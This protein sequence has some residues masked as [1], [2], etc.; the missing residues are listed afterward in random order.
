MGPDPGGPDPRRRRRWRWRRLWR[1]WR[2][3]CPPCRPGMKAFGRRALVLGAGYAL[4][5]LLL[6]TALGLLDPTRPKP[7][8]RLGCEVPRGPAGPGPLRLPEPRD[9]LVPPPQPPHPPD[10][11]DPLIPAPQPRHPLDPL[12]PHPRDP[13]IPGPQPPPHPPDPLIPESHP[14]DP[15]IPAPQPPRPPAPGVPGP[16][17][18]GP[19]QRAG[20]RRLVYVFTTWRSGSSFFGELFNQNPDVFFLYEPVWHVWQKLY[21]GDAVSLQGAARDM[22][23]ALYRCDLSV[24]QLYG[25]AGGAGRNLT[26]LAIF[27]AATNKVVCS[28]PLCPAYR[29]DVVGLVDDRVCKKCPPQRLAR[30]EEQCHRYRVLAIKG[31]RVF[32]V[33]VLAPLLRDPALDLKVIHLVRD[34][35]AVASSRIRSRHGLIRESLQVVR[36]RDPRAHHVP[37]LEA[38]GHKAAAKK[39]GR[40]GPGGA[41][42]YHALGAMEVICGTMAKTL[43]TALRPPD[44]LRG[45][46]LV[47]RYEDLVGDPVKTLRRVYGFVGLLVSPDMERFALNMTSGSSS[48]SKPFVVS[49]RNAT[50]AASAWRT[51]LTFPQIKQVE[52]FCHQPM[53]LLGYERVSGPEE[54]K[55]LSKTLLREPRL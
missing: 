40:A 17:A 39:E 46:Y 29:K 48:S 47:V 25:P 14:P 1:L 18:S 32:D 45:R 11:R 28:W 15:L 35:R 36:S 34:P 9:P 51:A 12:I 8:P 52:E 13:L 19:S 31:V 24:F 10:P 33:A 3:R 23:S 7:D 44:W 37:F 38:A 26:T 6:L 53:A 22:L 55:D 54:V 41:A 5:L 42:D 43:Q 30:L 20:R 49:A 21:P 50:Q 4:L 2:C 16:L 27:G